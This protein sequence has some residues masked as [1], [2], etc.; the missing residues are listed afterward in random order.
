M[1]SVDEFGGA[2]L[3]NDKLTSV[4]AWDLTLVNTNKYYSTVKWITVVIFQPF[5]PVWVKH[6]DCAVSNL[7]VKVKPDLNTR[8]SSQTVKPSEE[9]K[10]KMNVMYVK[11]LWLF[12]CSEFFSC[13]L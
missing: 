3:I 2:D 12:C 10:Q 1:P 13:R 8:V 11:L 4:T 5:P 7:E 9:E 6:G